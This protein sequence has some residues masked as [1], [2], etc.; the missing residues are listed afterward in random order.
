MGKPKEPLR[1]KVAKV[2]NRTAQYDSYSIELDLDAGSVNPEIQDYHDFLLRKADE[3]IKMVRKESKP[4]KPNT[5]IKGP[6]MSIISEGGD[7]PKK[8]VEYKP[9]EQMQ[10]FVDN[11][12]VRDWKGKKVR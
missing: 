10:V 3:I 4:K 8:E 11:G 12:T 9:L 1:W 5:K 6:G 2:L 7:T